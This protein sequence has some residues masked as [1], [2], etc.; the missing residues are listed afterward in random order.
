MKYANG[1]GVPQNNA[2][3]VKW[4]R[5]AAEKGEADAQA[6]LAV[7]Y[8]DGNG[9]PQDYAEAVK[10]FRLAGETDAQYNL[11]VM[12]ANGEGVPKDAV[13]AY[14]WFSVAAAQGLKDAAKTRDTAK[15]KLTP[16]QLKKGQRQ[17][18]EC[19]ERYGSGK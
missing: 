11:G 5:L 14:V 6:N 17:A 4:Y 13:E 7:M 8:R 18:T 12:Y 9:V 3:A 19:F 10:W 1:T 2:E 16:E 15:E